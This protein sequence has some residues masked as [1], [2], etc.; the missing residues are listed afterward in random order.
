M[1]K[2]IVIC[3]D[4]T[5]NDVSGDTSNVFKLY[6]CLARDES[7]L[8]YYIPGVGTVAD[9]TMKT[10]WGKWW[11]RKL[12]M[13]VGYGVR[14]LVCEA[15]R[16]LCENYEEGDKIYLFGFSRGAY[17]VRATAGM[18]NFLGLLRPEQV[19][20]ERHA[21]ALYANDDEIMS[22]R[23]SYKA[24]HRFRKAFC[25]RSKPLIHF[26]G[27][28][29]TVSSFGWLWNLKTLRYTASNGL[30]KHARHAVAT[31]ERRAMFRQNLIRKHERTQ[32]LREV[33]MPGG[34]GD[35]GG[36]WPDEVNGYS[37]LALSWMVDEARPFGVRFDEQLLNVYTSLA[38]EQGTARLQINDALKGSWWLIELLPRRVWDPRKKAMRWTWPNF[39]RERRMPPDAT[40]LDL[41]KNTKHVAMD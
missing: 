7:Q 9:P 14:E 30:I 4:G 2:S 25:R 18:I 35:V 3:C 16:F 40:V 26:L 28:W 23:E 6:R 12:D 20:L 17:T 21:W 27:V 41:A 19:S 38:N 33:W 32:S 22:L 10:K 36:G 1:P 29:D 37:R 34:H 31:D 11:S 39:G 8:T 13:G 5:S 15:Y 24:A